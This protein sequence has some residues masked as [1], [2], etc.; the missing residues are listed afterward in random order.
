MA[1]PKK[2]VACESLAALPLLPSLACAPC[3]HARLLL[4]TRAPPGEVRLALRGDGL[5]N[6]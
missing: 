1:A 5:G 6:F 2:R 4:L 3:R